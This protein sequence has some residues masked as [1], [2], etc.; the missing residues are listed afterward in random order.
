MDSF[1]S[2]FHFIFSS[3]GVEGERPSS[4]SKNVKSNLS[5]S[6]AVFPRFH[7]IFTC[8]RFY[9]EFVAERVTLCIANIPDFVSIIYF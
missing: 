9:V 7:D 5:L 4:A 6:F 2:T 3:N 1:L 8:D